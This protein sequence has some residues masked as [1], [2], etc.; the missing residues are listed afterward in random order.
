M[1]IISRHV[2]WK[3]RNSCVCEMVGLGSF[4]APR[5]LFKLCKVTLAW[6]VVVETTVYHRPEKLKD[7]T[8]NQS[9]TNEDFFLT[10]ENDG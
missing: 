1:I 10:D 4:L 6:R 9:S 3:V 7:M 8:K 2:L 5:R